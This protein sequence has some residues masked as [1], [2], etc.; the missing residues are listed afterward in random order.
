MLRKIKLMLGVLAVLLLVNA[1]GSG[2]GSN[3]QKTWTIFVYGHADNN[4][5]GSFE[6]D[7]ARMAEAT[8]GNDIYFV[9]AVDWNA[10]MTKQAGG[11][12]PTGTEWYLVSGGGVKTLIRTEVEQDSDKPATLSNQI[13]Y[14]FNTY[15]AQRYGLIFWDHGGSWDYGFGGDS[16]DGTVASPVSMSLTDI[17]TGITQ[18]L[19]SAFITAPID[20]I[21][22]DTCLLGNAELTYLLK[23]LSKVYISDA[24]VDFGWS[25]DFAGT[26]TAL[27]SDPNM[28]A[29]AFAQTE[30]AKWDAYHSNPSSISDIYLRSHV[31]VDNAKVAEFSA[32]M[33]DLVDTIRATKGSGTTLPDGEAIAASA[34]FSLPVYGVTASQKTNSAQYRDVGQ[35]LTNL[36]VRVG[37]DIGAKAQIAIDKLIAMELGKSYGIFR[38]PSQYDQ[39]AF[40]IALPEISMITDV[41]LADYATKSAAWNTATGWG[42]FLTDLKATKPDTKPTGVQTRVGD[43]AT[44]TPNSSAVSFATMELLQNI[45]ETY[46][47]YGAVYFGV[48]DQGIPYPM[49]WDR[50]IWKVGSLSQPSAVVPWIYR[51]NE[52]FALLTAITDNLLGAYGQISETTTKGTTTT[53]GVLVFSSNLTSDQTTATAIAQNNNGVWDI[54]PIVDFVKEHKDAAFKPAL[55]NYTNGELYFGSNTAEALPANGIVAV[56]KATV[57]G[58]TY[59]FQTTLDDV[60]GNSQGF[61]DTETK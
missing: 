48:V 57:D 9:V 13:S 20:F 16:Q 44:F 42:G 43:T 7:L 1:C 61:T 51:A 8:L 11:N 10:S 29:Q 38:D 60:W 58:G 15:P 30:V 49:T 39:L 53:T 28:T 54:S 52:D 6:G 4:L 50:K 3:P 17:S 55:L 24:E 33:K 40:Q 5:A 21:I 14:A 47:N 27:G 18:G 45:S 56:S 22:F 37:G 31:A 23:D 32:A 36:I 26:F 41:V 19:A 12:F 35:F 25:L 46:V 59:I 34:A 2:G